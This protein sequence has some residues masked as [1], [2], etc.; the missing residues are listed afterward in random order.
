MKITKG[1]TSSEL[2]EILKK[3]K[4]GTF[5]FLKIETVLKMNKK[6]NLYFDKIKKKSS[7][8]VLLGANY[9]NRVNNNLLKEEKESNFIAESCKVGQHISECVLYNENT[10]LFYLQ[11]EFFKEIQPRVEYF[12]N[13]NII[14]KEK[15]SEFLPQKSVAN[16]NGLV[17]KVNSITVKVQNIKEITLNKVK[18]FVS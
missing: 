4:I 10:Q 14:E 15:F 18:Y 13:G 11:Y 8:N 7:Q 16:Q 12:F 5:A 9:Q 6:N 1:I 17:K 2:V 3:Q